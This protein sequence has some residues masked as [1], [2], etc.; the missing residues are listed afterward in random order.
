MIDRVAAKENALKP[1]ALAR[2]LM[3]EAA[4]R[5]LSPASV[6][7]AVALPDCIG[8]GSAWRTPLVD[9]AIERLMVEQESLSSKLSRR[10]QAE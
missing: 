7:L 5:S 1:G 8:Q 2:E 3:L 10:E 4:Q 6:I 9:S